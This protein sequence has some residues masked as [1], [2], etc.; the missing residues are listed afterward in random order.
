MFY[1]YQPCVCLPHKGSPGSLWHKCYPCLEI[2]GHYT[3]NIII[4]IHKPMN[5]KEASFQMQNVVTLESISISLNIRYLP[6]LAPRALMTQHNAFCR[7]ASEYTF[8]IGMEKGAYPWSPL[9]GSRYGGTAWPEQL[10]ASSNPQ[11]A[12]WISSEIPEAMATHLYGTPFAYSNEV[13][14]NWPSLIL[15]SLS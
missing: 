13:G 14:Y 9:V 5:Y 11:L 7:G 2:S 4:I 1:A 3:I 6:K 15:F 8:V 12:P 10:G